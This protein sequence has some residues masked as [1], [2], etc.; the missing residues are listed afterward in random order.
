MS[1]LTER[2]KEAGIDKDAIEEARDEHDPKAA[3]IQLIL[4]GGARKV[5]PA[6]LRAELGEYAANP[7]AT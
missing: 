7:F 2:A 3:L 6:A 4:E 1:K 5:D